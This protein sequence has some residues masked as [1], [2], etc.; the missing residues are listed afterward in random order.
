MI[1]IFFTTNTFKFSKALNYLT[2]LE[3]PSQIWATECHRRRLRLFKTQHQH[4]SHP[5]AQMSLLGPRHPI[6]PC[7]LIFHNFLVTYTYFI[8]HFE[9]NFI[10]IPLFYYVFG[11][12]FNMKTS[13]ICHEKFIFTLWASMMT[14]LAKVS[15]KVLER[16]RAR[17]GMSTCIPPSQTTSI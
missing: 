9:W 5:L 3:S 10:I 12:W 17:K 4:L 16:T 11:L 13:W 2:G 8:F 15:M 14:P 7:V 1:T 6:L